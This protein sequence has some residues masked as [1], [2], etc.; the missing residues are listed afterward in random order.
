MG[1]ALALSSAFF[2]GLANVYA[3]RGNYD[4]GVNPHEGLLL[5]IIVNNAIN[6][7]L[8]PIIFLFTTLPAFNWLGVFSYVGAGFFTSFVGRTLLY[9]GI[10]IIG[11]SRSGSFKITAPLF[12]ILIAVLVLKEQIT[13]LHMLGI[14]VILAGVLIVI[15][16]TQGSAKIAGALDHKRSGAEEKHEQ[17]PGQEERRHQENKK[18]RTGIIIALLSGL[19]FG[20]GNVL[21]K[22]GVLYYPNP[23]MGGVINSFASLVF[24]LAFI[25]LNPIRSLMPVNVGFKHLLKRKG[26]ME[27]ILSGVGTSCAI[28][29]LY[30]SLS[31]LKVAIV[32]TIASIEV[33]FTILIAAVLLKNREFIS[34]TLVFGAAIIIAGISIIYL[35]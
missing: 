3:S 32:N 20:I 30:F 18:T 1:L 10:L 22:V 24:L 26:S 17:P 13:A 31:F 25:F 2:F 5:T 14:T 21:R 29:S 16:E 34:R 28:Y 6:I 7:L 33:L 9:S 35:F 23:L 19:S 8:L 12:T 27:Y 15:R 4:G 11:A